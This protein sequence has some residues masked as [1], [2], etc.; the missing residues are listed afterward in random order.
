MGGERTTH[1]HGDDTVVPGSAGQHRSLGDDA[2]TANLFGG[3][4]DAPAAAQGIGG[5]MAYRP[6][7]RLGQ[8]TLRHP[9]GSGGF[10]EVWL[11]DSATL[12]RTV[13]IKL[14]RHEPNSV[15]EVARFAAEAQALSRLEHECIARIIEFSDGTAGSAQANS[16]TSGES[17]DSDTSASW[18]TPGVPWI[19]MEFI[20]GEAITT[21]CD[22]RRLSMAQRLELVARVCDAIHHAHSRQVLHRDLKPD[23][24]LVTEMRLEPDSVPPRDRLLV[25]G[26]ERGAAIVARPKVVDFG[27]AKSLD[28]SLRLADNI[29]TREFNV[30]IGTLPYMAPEQAAAD[31]FGIDTRADIFALGVVL[32]ELIVG[33][34]PLMRAELADA[35]NYRALEKIRESPRPEPSTRFRSLTPD[36]ATRAAAARQEPNAERLGRRLG[37]RV[38]HLTGTALRIDRERRFSSAAAF[39]K[40]I[41]NYLDDEPFEEAAAEPITRRLWLSIR[42]RPLPFVAAAVVALS[43]T[44][45]I[46][47]LVLLHRTARNAVHTQTQHLERETTHTAEARRKGEQLAAALDE[48]KAASEV[49]DLETYTASLDAARRMLASGDPG[50]ALAQLRRC[51]LDLRGWEWGHLWTRAELMPRTYRF[52]SN[53][54]IQFAFV[55]DHSEL[56]HTSGYGYALAPSIAYD[57]S[58][59]LWPFPPSLSPARTLHHLLSPDGTVVWYLPEDFSAGVGEVVWRDG[60]AAVLGSSSLN[61]PDTSWHSFARD[62]R[63][64]IVCGRDGMVH[65]WDL[66]PGNAHHA[67]LQVD[68]YVLAA[69]RVGHLLALAVQDTPTADSPSLSTLY[70]WELPDSAPKAALRLDANKFQTLPHLSPCGRCVAACGDDTT[71]VWQLSGDK[72]QPFAVLAGSLP[73]WSRAF[74]ADGSILATVVTTSGRSEPLAVHLFALSEGLPPTDPV[75]RAEGGSAIGFAPEGPYAAIGFGDGTVRTVELESMTFAISPLVLPHAVE[76]VAISRFGSWVAAHSGL[77]LSSAH[78]LS[79]AQPF[80]LPELAE[81]ASPYVTIAAAGDSLVRVAGDSGGLQCEAWRLDTSPPR[82]IAT[83]SLSSMSQARVHPDGDLVSGLDTSGSLQFVRLRQQSDAHQIAHPSGKILQ[84]SVDPMATRIA[85]STDGGAIAIGRLGADPQFMEVRHDGSNVYHLRFSPDGRRVEARSSLGKRVWS[86]SGHLLFGGSNADEQVAGWDVSDDLR[87]SAVA[88]KTGGID[89]YDLEAGGQVRTLTLDIQVASGLEFA[90][91]A[92]LLR[93]QW[94]DGRA[95]LW[96]VSRD[97]VPHWNLVD[98]SGIEMIALPRLGALPTIFE[99][100]MFGASGGIRRVYLGDPPTTDATW[101]ILDGLGLHPDGSLVYWRGPNLFYLNPANSR[102]PVLLL[103]AA[104]PIGEA[105][106][107][108]DGS[109]LTTVDFD[110]VV[111]VYD[112]IP[113]SYRHRLDLYTD[114]VISQQDLIDAV[115]D[116]RLEPWEIEP[117]PWVTRPTLPGRGTAMSESGRPFN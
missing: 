112:S 92:S 117:I 54:H 78:R 56:V 102:D 25:V 30:P 63:S 72:T 80:V 35:A 106:F 76:Q 13:A 26:N 28:P 81:V 44:V 95:S 17:R 24:I 20:R 67:H 22:R 36:D 3:D 110:E 71:Y 42:R 23:N 90:S 87:W 104:A 46:A 12:G 73:P 75:Y 15:V 99:G 85:I 89:L 109:R 113:A 37:G 93:A 48:L 61:L 2:P 41:R 5:R 8:Y 68:G 65:T 107:T 66:V 49:R 11:A 31:P 98:L 57:D 16:G 9:L 1:P 6:G 19:A 79:H 103:N 62:G 58:T 33:V 86:I 83:V 47:A 14:L 45:A 40:D 116:G 52:D 34:P 27:L 4:V 29:H 114:G 59:A 32:Y 77:A 38:R 101:I 100:Q 105:A 70:L 60:R 55:G 96:D 97:P 94:S 111:R 64:I 91:G 18:T 7:Q 82:K 108:S 39:A 88:L 115:D 51:R 69:D 43:M 53:P 21:Y 50:A 74:S 10:G 84:W